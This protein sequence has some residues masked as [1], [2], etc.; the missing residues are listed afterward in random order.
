MTRPLNIVFLEPYY[1]G[2]HKVFLD[3]LAA[4]GRHHFTVISMP[5]RKWKWR[6]RGAAIHFARE[7]TDWIKSHDERA[8]DLIVCSD[9]LAINDLKALLPKTLSDVKVLCYFHENQLTYPLQEN[10]ERDFQ[11]GMTN[12]LSCLAADA[13]WFNSAFHR[14]E[15]I[16]SVGALLAQMP[17]FVPKSVV[18]E[19]TFKSEVYY[20]PVLIDAT[21]RAGP[22]QKQQNEPLTFLW[23]HRWEYDKN[24]RPFLEA[25]VD[26]YTSGRP[27]R[28]VLVGEEFDRAPRDVAELLVRLKPVITHGGW[29]PDRQTYLKWLQKADIVV[30]SSIQENFGLAVI[31]AIL[32]G[33]QPLLPDRLVYP[34]IIPLELHGRCLYPG[35]ASLGKRLADLI[36]GQGRLTSEEMAGLQSSLTD[37]FGPAALEAIGDGL[38]RIAE[39]R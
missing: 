19:I 18:S 9:M 28:L 13:V 8:I 33:C 29:V 31:E 32:S 16:K 30:S 21:Y 22:S 10:E 17:D 26:L 11:Y 25:L 7:A 39:A 1:G 27:F 4:H 12:I 24:P 2:S 6:M 23:S 15:F 34:E 38:N 35:D 36:D 5:A 20:P 3:T 37:R 14:D